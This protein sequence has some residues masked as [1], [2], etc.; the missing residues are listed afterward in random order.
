MHACYI[1]CLH[2]MYC[3]SSDSYA[4]S[5]CTGVLLIKA[6]E[7]IR[8]MCINPCHNLNMC[9]LSIRDYWDKRTKFGHFMNML[10]MV[11]VSYVYHENH[12]TSVCWCLKFGKDVRILYRHANVPLALY[13]PGLLKKGTYSSPTIAH[14]LWYHLKLICE[15]NRNF[16]TKHLYEIV[17]GLQ[18]V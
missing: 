17:S 2:D 10:I 6:R 18:V 15:D 13:Q 1:P 14:M 8:T 11:K 5:P 3:L 7:H 4:T 12:E 16:R 9:E